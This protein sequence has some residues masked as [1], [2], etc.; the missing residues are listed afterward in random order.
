M[1][2]LLIFILLSN[3]LSKNKTIVKT[4][5][6]ALV[7]ILVVKKMIHLWNT[8][9]QPFWLHVVYNSASQTWR[10]PSSAHFVCLPYLTHLI[11][12]ISSLVEAARHE[13]GVSD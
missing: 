3:H 4:V 11:Q 13:L 10:T 9:C 6:I 1:I 12:L 7:I 8:G 5:N 2:Y